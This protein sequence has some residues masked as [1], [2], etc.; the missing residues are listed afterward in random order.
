MSVLDQASGVAA[1]AKLL[2]LAELSTP[3]QALVRLCQLIDYGQ[4]TNLQIRDGEP[5]FDPEP[6]VVVEIKLDANGGPRP[7]S[8]L[9]D[10]TLCV[11]VSHLIRQIE[12]L[13]SGSI[14]R[15]EVRAGIPRRILFDARLASMGIEGKVE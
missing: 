15:I 8:K 1:G 5:V 2:R 7:E 4:I 10:F 11:E 13:H 14:Q 9:A 6:S 3:S 12:Q